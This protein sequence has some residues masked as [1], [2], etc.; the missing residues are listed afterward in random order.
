MKKENKENINQILRDTSEFFSWFR[1]DIP[2]EQDKTYIGPI[3]K[4]PGS[5]TA[6]GN[7]PRPNIPNFKNDIPPEQDKTY[8]GPIDKN[9]E[10]NAANGNQTGPGQSYNQNKQLEAL[11]TL[12]NAIKAEKQTTILDVNDLEDL[13]NAIKKETQC[14]DDMRSITRKCSESLSSL[15]YD[16][17]NRLRYRRLESD[18]LN[19]ELLSAI[20]TVESQLEDITNNINTQIE[21]IEQAN[22]TRI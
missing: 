4:N 1:S 18:S 8:I 17:K 3:D 16:I 5:N 22:V 13:S 2:P 20:S 21:N 19:S 15:N 7:Q 11:K 9:S 14:I 6:S 10:S 12:K